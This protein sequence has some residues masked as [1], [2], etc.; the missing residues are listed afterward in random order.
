MS[1]TCFGVWDMTETLTT[2]LVKK[3]I[4]TNYISELSCPVITPTKEHI[5]AIEYLARPVESNNI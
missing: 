3:K 1:K 2:T 5:T 4:Q